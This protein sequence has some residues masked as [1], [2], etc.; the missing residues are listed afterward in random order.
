MVADPPRLNSKSMKSLEMAGSG[1]AAAGSI[2]SAPCASRLKD[3]RG[4]SH[5]YGT[6]AGAAGGGGR[7]LATAE[8]MDRGGGHAHQQSPSTATRCCC[9]QCGA[10]G[11]LSPADALPVRQ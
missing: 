5:P 4:L 1:V 9:T 2:M 11:T 6:A 8:A 7:L 3:T 10:A